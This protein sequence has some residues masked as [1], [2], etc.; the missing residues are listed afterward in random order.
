MVGSSRKS[1]CCLCIYQFSVFPMVIISLSL[2]CLAT[3][4]SV[5]ASD[6]NNTIDQLANCKYSDDYCDGCGNDKSLEWIK[7][8][9]FHVYEATMN[10]FG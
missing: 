3:Y 4:S 2:A 10:V 7:N 5:N 6:M 9:N 8:V 1:K